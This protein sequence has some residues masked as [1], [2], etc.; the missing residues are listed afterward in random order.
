MLWPN[1]RAYLTVLPLISPNL[2]SLFL[3]SLI[4]LPSI[5]HPLLEN[6]LLF[7]SSYLLF[8]GILLLPFT[9]PPL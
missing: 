4:P 9:P 2:L 3:A 1:Q 6:V 5:S 8:P 7:F